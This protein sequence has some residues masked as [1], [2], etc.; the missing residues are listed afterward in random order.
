[1]LVSAV[2][3]VKVRADDVSITTAAE[4]FIGKSEEEIANLARQILV[5]GMRSVLGKIT[6]AELVSSLDKVAIE[7]QECVQPQLAKLGLTCVAFSIGEIKDNGYL[8]SHVRTQNEDA[9]KLANEYEQV[10]PLLETTLGEQS[11]VFQDLLSRYAT[12]LAGRKDAISLAKAEE[13]KV[14]AGK[15]MGP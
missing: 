2:A 9:Q 3:Q 6:V 13:L 10:L 8:E 4:Q 12:V 7:F 5:G 14:R 15:Q 11:L 1:V